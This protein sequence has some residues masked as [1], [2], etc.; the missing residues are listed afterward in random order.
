MCGRKQMIDVHRAHTKP[1]QLPILQI[2]MSGISNSGISLVLNHHPPL[3]P[4][5]GQ[6]NVH[7]KMR[8]K[9]NANLRGYVDIYQPTHANL[10][11]Q[12]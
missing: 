10:C 3:P 11:E 2:I 6:S 7:T 5:Q 1:P 4:P 8:A 12:G 9:P